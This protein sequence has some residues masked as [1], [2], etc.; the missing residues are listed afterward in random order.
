MSEKLLRPFNMLQMSLDLGN[1]LCCTLLNE[2]RLSSYERE[3][4]IC[5][6]TRVRLTFMNSEYRS[7]FCLSELESRPFL[8]KKWETVQCGSCTFWWFPGSFY[9]FF[10]DC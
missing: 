5:I 8:S 10:P 3:K 6:H 2:L 1:F 4:K 7:S 9:P